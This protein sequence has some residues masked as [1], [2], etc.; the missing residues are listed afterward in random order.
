M[1]MFGGAIMP[2]RIILMVA[3]VKMSKLIMWIKL[4]TNLLNK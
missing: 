3:L 4:G 1:Y 2:S